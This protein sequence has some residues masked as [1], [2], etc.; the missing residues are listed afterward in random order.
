MFRNLAED[1]AY[2]LIKNKIVD[3]ERRDIYVFGIEVLL[4]N[5]LNI[6]TALVVSIVTG[7]KLHFLAFIFVFIPLRIFSGGY[8]AKTSEACYLITTVTYVL[9]VLCVKR[10]PDIYSSIPG[11]IA[12][13]VLIVPMILLAPIEHRNNPLSTYERKR[14]RLI[15]IVLIVFDSL[16]FIAMFLLSTSA[17]TSVLIFIAINSIIMLIGSLANRLTEK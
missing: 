17:A 10:F 8:H 6:L 14:N 2:L 11:L 5:S 13:S 9:S 16:V 4:L 3:I 1:I 12:L 15:S 7:T